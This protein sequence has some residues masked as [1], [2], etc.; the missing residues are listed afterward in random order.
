[1]EAVFFAGAVQALFFAVI[2]LN[3][4]NKQTA[5]N[6]L[7]IWLITLA[8]TL[9]G[10]FLFFRQDSFSN[11]VI[12]VV[13]VGL[14]ASQPVWF[15]LYTCSLTDKFRSFQIKELLHFIPAIVVVVLFIPFFK[16]DAQQIEGIYARTVALP[17]L[18][19]FGGIPLFGLIY[20]Y[21][22]RSLIRI[23]IHKKK[24]KYL[25]S[26]E[27]NIDLSWLLKLTYS[28]LIIIVFIVT[29]SGLYIFTDTKNGWIYDY[30]GGVCYV[31]FVFALG[32]F[33]YKQGKIFSHSN[34]VLEVPSKMS[35]SIESGS[36]RKM[37]AEEYASMASQLS[38]YAIANKPWLKEKISLYDLAHELDL[39]SHQLSSLLNDY[40]ETSFY[41][42]IN[43]HRVE[44]V[45]RRL[46][47]NN[48]QFT[49]LA[50]A[51]ECGFNSKASFNRIFKQKT[52]LTPSEYIKANKN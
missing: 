23:R 12:I 2:I 31:G 3:K 51:L 38:N 29:I 45:K 18:T 24:L 10:S 35:V 22:I 36:G 25:F 26:Y 52:G 14:L 49:F 11:S 16:L 8:V 17:R 13:S 42:Y 43:H 7:S 41:D 30:L 32:Y 33:G 47:N 6:I 46:K 34:L 27:E 1:M 19:L 39:T 5:D 9:F 37:A 20:I 50:I 15:Y 28:F 44:E 21:I 4:K 40:L 48:N